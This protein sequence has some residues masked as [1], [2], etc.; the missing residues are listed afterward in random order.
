MVT[1]GIESEAIKVKKSEWQKNKCEWLRAVENIEAIRPYS[2]AMFENPEKIKELKRMYE[3]YAGF[4][5]SDGE[6]IA[7]GVN[8]NEGYWQDT[9]DGV[10]KY[11]FFPES[12]SAQGAIFFKWSRKDRPRIELYAETIDASLYALVRKMDCI[13]VQFWIGASRI[14]RAEGLF[15]YTRRDHKDDDIRPNWEIVM[16][17]SVKYPNDKI[18]KEFRTPNCGRSY[19][20]KEVG[21]I[22]PCFD[23]TLLENAVD[24]Q[25][26]P[27]LRDPSFNGCSNNH[28]ESLEKYSSIFKKRKTEKANRSHADKKVRAIFEQKF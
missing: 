5:N 8:K 4:F 12:I 24:G 15:R 11:G 6:L 1:E 25:P 27:S 13:M 26:P 18:W 20:P 3:P 7:F 17:D 22:A 16:K 19:R 2:F 14:A 28:P 9:A 21:E 10:L 23:P